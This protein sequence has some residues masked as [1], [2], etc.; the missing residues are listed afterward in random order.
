MLNV[1]ATNIDI[2]IGSLAGCVASAGGFC[3]GASLMVEHQR[4][5]S[6]AVTF[7]ASLPT[8][9]TT[10]ASEVITRLQ[11]AQGVELLKN[12]QDRI[13]TLRH[14]LIQSDWVRCT[15][16]PQNPVIML[17]LKEEH[18]RERC[19]SRG[20]Q[21]TLLQQCVDEVNYKPNR[22]RNACA[23][24]TVTAG[25]VK[26]QHPH[27]PPQDHAAHGWSVFARLG[28][29]MVAGAGYQSLRHFGFVAKGD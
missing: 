24:L 26:P 6:P 17:V 22:M 8:F 29:R 13:T 2:I 28:Q 3:T 15:S 4:L 27:N 20:E 16:A 9:L 7:S 21:E 5:N 25:S 18:V 14:Q 19:L 11:T 23:K 12:L 1:D 10:T